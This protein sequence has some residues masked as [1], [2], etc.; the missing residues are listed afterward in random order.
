MW[1][2]FPWLQPKLPSL[3]QT[4]LLLM[5]HRLH[6][7]FYHI[8][9][10]CLTCIIDIFLQN[11]SVWCF[12]GDLLRVDSCIINCH[13]PE[14]NHFL[15]QAPHLLASFFW[16]LTCKSPCYHVHFRV[17]F[18][19]RCFAM[20]IGEGSSE[21]NRKFVV[22]RDFLMYFLVERHAVI[23][24]ESMGMGTISYVLDIAN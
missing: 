7:H 9:Y 12:L 1:P 20:L 14:S 11:S 21:C 5:S 8:V 6:G 18:F 15:L 13:D 10:Q 23:I 3:R 22:H 24:G 19:L 16:C 4:L 17:S 2:C